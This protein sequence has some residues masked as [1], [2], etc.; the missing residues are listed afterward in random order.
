MYRVVVRVSYPGYRKEHRVLLMKKWISVILVVGMLVTLSACSLTKQSD[1][2]YGASSQLAKI[3][4]IPEHV[5]LRQTDVLRGR[6]LGC[7]IAYKGDEW[8]AALSNALEAVG[9]VSALQAAGNTHVKVFSMDGYGSE[10]FGMLKSGDINYEAC[11]VANIWLFAQ[12]IFNAI[13]DYYEGR[14]V[15]NITYI[16]LALLDQDNIDDYWDMG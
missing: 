2:F 3:Q 1:E 9:A 6:K 13:V 15:D 4:S 10:P 5:E 12:D 8:C 7:S 14:E 11:V 16:D